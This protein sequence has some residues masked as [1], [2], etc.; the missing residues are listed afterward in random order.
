MKIVN[1]LLDQ[2][3]KDDG[4]EKLK[5]PIIPKRKIPLDE[6]FYNSPVKM[7][8]PEKTEDKALTIL[9]SKRAKLLENKKNLKLKTT[10]EHTIVKSVIYLELEL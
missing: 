3:I 10:K 2:R 8:I 4:K 7:Y 1:K 5:L 6:I 9:K